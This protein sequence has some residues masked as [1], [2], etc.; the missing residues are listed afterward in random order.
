M[1]CTDTLLRAKRLGIEG[2]ADV[3]APTLPFEPRGLPVPLLA[4]LLSGAGC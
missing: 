4:R 2:C 1:M 3:Q